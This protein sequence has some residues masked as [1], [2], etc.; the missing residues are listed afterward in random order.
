MVRQAAF[1]K[2]GVMKN[3][4]FATS[5]WVESGN[6]MTETS[7]QCLNNQLARVIAINLVCLVIFIAFCALMTFGSP[8]R[9]L[10][11]WSEHRVESVIAIMFA[12]VSIPGL[13]EV[14]LSR[15]EF[16]RH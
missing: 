7:R 8:T 10:A 1:G 9:L 16:W 2:S 11:F 6:P 13:V 14:T 4:L 3:L 5:F 12:I 15:W